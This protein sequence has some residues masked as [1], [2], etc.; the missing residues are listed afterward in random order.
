MTSRKVSKSIAISQDILHEIETS[1]NSGKIGNLDEFV[2]MAL[3]RELEARRQTEIDAELA[4]MAKD[5]DY[6]QEVTQLESEFAEADWEAFEIG[7]N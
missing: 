3:R 7:V 4:E 2:E 6:L 1:I 5:P